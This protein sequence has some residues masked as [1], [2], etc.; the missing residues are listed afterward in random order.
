MY[1]IS[2]ATS[3]IYKEQFVFA[4]STKFVRSEKDQLISEEG[5]NDIGNVVWELGIFFVSVWLTRST[6][7][8]NI[9]ILILALGH[10]FV[11][12]AELT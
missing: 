2:F 12:N 9:P 5:R 4:L 7:F 8:F 3:R 10:P 11:P 1:D 6:I